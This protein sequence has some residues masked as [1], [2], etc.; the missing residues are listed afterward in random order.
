MH[1]I[2]SIIHLNMQRNAVKDGKIN[3]FMN[4][5]IKIEVK[6]T[7]YLKECYGRNKMIK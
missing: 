2:C 6:M 5:K 4:Y 3:F 7:R 1:A